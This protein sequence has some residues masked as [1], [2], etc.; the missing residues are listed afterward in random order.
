MINFPPGR[1]TKILQDLEQGSFTGIAEI[2]VEKD[3]SKIHNSQ[4]LVFR[5]GKLVFA[6][7]RQVSPQE[8]ATIL[9]QRLDISIINAAIKTAQTKVAN[10]DSFQE[11]FS[12]LS[13][14][15][16]IP[17]TQLENLI[18]QDIVLGLEKLLPYGGSLQTTSQTK[19]DL[20]YPS[21]KDG[22]SF[23][24]LQSELQK[25][26]QK[27][28]HY[29]KVGI[30]SADAVPKINQEE[31]KNISSTS[32]QKHCLKW[33]NGERSLGTIAQNIQEDPLKLAHNY[34]SWVHKKWIYFGE[35]PSVDELVQLPA[36][37]TLP[38]ETKLPT[39]LSVD[40][41]PVVQTMLKRAMS[42]RYEVILANNG[43][44]ALKVLNSHQKEIRL[45][46]LDVTMPDIDG[47]E[48]C[49]TI[50]RFKKFQDLPIIMLTAKDGMFDK[51]KGKFAGSTEYLTKPVDK[52]NL[53]NTVGK[54]I[55]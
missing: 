28:S 6:H 40:D 13:R 48:L 19:F 47:I 32:A 46:L 8:L 1:L 41:S 31:I 20:E 49:R 37:S 36:A 18:L 15:K 16:I 54:Y 29:G 4:I 53:L 5:A 26:Q 11:I 55:S 52:E 39:V 27:W 3:D 30:D 24:E 34:Y 23:I 35:K 42:D 45:I 25:R 44:Q 2:E 17:L 33:I 51:V 10:S 21:Q 9:G 22:W 7:D 14:M 12:F 43:M 38:V 50:R